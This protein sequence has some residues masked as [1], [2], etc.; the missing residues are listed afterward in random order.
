MGY[1]QPEIVYEAVFC[2]CPASV[3]VLSVHSVAQIYG[4]SGSAKLGLLDRTV[5]IRA[6]AVAG[7]RFAKSFQ[8]VPPSSTA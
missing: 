7:A 5:N 2:E 6:C 4:Y 8:E 3:R 1:E